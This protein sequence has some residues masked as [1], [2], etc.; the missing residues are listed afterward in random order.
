MQNFQEQ[1]IKLL[2]EKMESIPD[3]FLAQK[4]QG[5]GD[6]QKVIYDLVQQNKTFFTE[7][8]FWLFEQ[9]VLLNKKRDKTQTIAIVTE[10]NNTEINPIIDV[11]FYG[12]D[13][14]FTL[15]NEEFEKALKKAKLNTTQ[16]KAANNLYAFSISMKE[17]IKNM[18]G[19]IDVNYV[20]KGME[21]QFKLT[22]QAL[23]PREFD[24]IKTH[25]GKNI[26]IDMYY[27]I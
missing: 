13:I 9:Q 12:F 4:K 15:S 6:N 16:E 3:F 21:R 20:F 5:S 11:S 27:L 2:I 7:I 1:E 23:Y 26:A 8:G 22:G 25:C 14:D 10:Q 19:K 17:L 24:D 18:Y